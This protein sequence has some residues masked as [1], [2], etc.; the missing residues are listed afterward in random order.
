MGL[1]GPSFTALDD[2]IPILSGGRLRRD[3]RTHNSTH[4]VALV[5]SHRLQPHQFRQTVVHLM[6]LDTY[7]EALYI[8]LLNTPS[9]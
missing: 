6:G 3:A 4:N 1:G 2:V 5:R 9:C 8:L 7:S